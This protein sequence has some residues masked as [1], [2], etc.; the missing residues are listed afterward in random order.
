MLG[1]VVVRRG[2]APW[3]T[4]LAGPRL[5]CWPWFTLAIGVF[6]LAYANRL[7]TYPHDAPWHYALAQRLARGEFPPV[8][9]YGVD[10]GIGY[11]YGA[12]LLA[13]TI[14]STTGAPPL[15]GFR[16]SLDVLL[17]VG[18]V[19]G[20]AGLAYDVGAPM[21]LALGLGAAV[22]FYSMAAMF[23]GYRTGSCRRASRSLGRPPSPESSSCVC[24]GLRLAATANGHRSQSFVV[25]ATLHAG[26]GKTAGADCWW[27]EQAS[28]ALGDG[29]GHDLRLCGA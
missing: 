22:G 20:V 13:A 9:P 3:D 8:T 12:D 21:P 7:H 26:V 6:A 1:V 10:A 23:L 28:L 15:D 4:G 14:I 18:L 19:L 24:S 5:R 17:I 29:L 27:R 25:A 2:S 11:H 16:C